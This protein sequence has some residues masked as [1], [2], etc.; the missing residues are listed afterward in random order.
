MNNK[1]IKDNMMTIIP[2]PLSQIASQIIVHKETI[3]EKMK[4]IGKMKNIVM[5]PNT[6]ILII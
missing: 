5:N 6:I 3:K 2:L 4:M 1:I